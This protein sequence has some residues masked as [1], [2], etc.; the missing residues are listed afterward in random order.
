MRL[1]LSIIRWWVV[2]WWLVH[3]ILRLA[4]MLVSLPFCFAGVT[5]SVASFLHF[6]G[7]GYRRDSDL[8]SPASSLL[9]CYLP[10][11]S[12]PDLG[13]HLKAP[14]RCPWSLGPYCLYDSTQ[15]RLQSHI[16]GLEWS[17]QRSRPG[18]SIRPCRSFLAVLLIQVLVQCRS[19]IAWRRRGASRLVSPVRCY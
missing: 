10:Q 14:C 19:V 15:L 13:Y 4:S 17:Q 7:Q 8:R 3:L 12:R 1:I 6:H 16:S 9:R 5:S 11:L 2:S 18:H